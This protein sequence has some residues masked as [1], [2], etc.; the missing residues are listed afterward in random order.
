MS[1]SPSPPRPTTVAK[2]SFIIG[3]LAAAWVAFGFLLA[4]ATTG[5]N[6]GVGFEFMFIGLLSS[7][8]A[9]LLGIAQL[10]RGR[11]DPQQRRSKG[12]AVFGVVIGVVSLIAVVIIV[13]MVPLW[14]DL[15]HCGEGY[16]TRR[17]PEP[18]GSLRTINTAEVSYASTYTTGY[19]ETLVQLGPLQVQRPTNEGPG[20][21]D[22]VLATG[23]KESY[24][25]TYVPHPSS[26]RIDSYEIYADPV[27]PKVGGAR[28]Y[29]TDESGVIR[30]TDENRRATDSDTPLAG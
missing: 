14:L 13:G 18:V 5:R 2:A 30:F 4:W 7:L 21:I 1:L 23:V 19:S 26:G 10:R 6:C 29:F 28:H 22:K 24:R 8:V 17:E 3:I 20:P 12:R 25:Y 27:D 16:V 15:S 11:R 9:A